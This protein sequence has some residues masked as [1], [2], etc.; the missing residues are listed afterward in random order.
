MPSK[1][2]GAI[3]YFFTGSDVSSNFS[4]PGGYGLQW[5]IYAQLVARLEFTGATWV[6]GAGNL[7]QMMVHNYSIGTES[8]RSNHLVLG[9]SN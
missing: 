2:N 9:W 7:G 8:R 4:P 1:A 6:T 3:V 5:T